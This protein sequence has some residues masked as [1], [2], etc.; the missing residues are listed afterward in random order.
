MADKERKV[1]VTAKFAWRRDV[2]KTN[3]SAMD[4]PLSIEDLNNYLPCGR[5]HVQYSNALDSY[6]NLLF[7]DAV[8]PA[9]KCECICG[10]AIQE[11]CYICPVDDARIEKSAL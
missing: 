2:V 3:L 11:Q 9:P 10:Q 5:G 8:Q 4:P 1:N 6:F 7:A